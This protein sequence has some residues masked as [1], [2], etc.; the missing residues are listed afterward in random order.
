MKSKSELKAVLHFNISFPDWSDIQDGNFPVVLNPILKI[1]QTHNIGYSHSG[2]Y[3]SGFEKI[4][5]LEFAVN[6]TLKVNM[7]MNNITVL[8]ENE[9]FEDTV[10]L[11]VL[12]HS[13]RKIQRLRDSK[14]PK[15]DKVI[16]QNV[17]GNEAHADTTLSVSKYFGFLTVS[18]EQQNNPLA[19]TYSVKVPTIMATAELS[20]EGMLKNL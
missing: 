10:R 15:E 20:G 19:V 17:V 4:S 8:M 7:K 18:K 5:E 1:S 11:N 16:Y 2:N 3:I 12:K 13:E 9:G 6:L 14:N